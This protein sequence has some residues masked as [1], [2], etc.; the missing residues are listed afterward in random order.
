MVPMGC[1]RPSVSPELMSTNPKAFTPMGITAENVARRFEVSREQ[2]DALALESHRRAL[3]AIETGKFKGEIAPLEVD[4]FL[5][6]GSRKRV[7]FD[8]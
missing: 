8:S 6:D 1:H 3:A 2:Q 7:V 5:D 4:V